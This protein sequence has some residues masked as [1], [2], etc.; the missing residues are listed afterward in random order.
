[1]PNIAK[2]YDEDVLT[3]S[4]VSIEVLSPQKILEYS[5]CE[6]DKPFD[7]KTFIGTLSDPK[8]GPINSDTLCKTCGYGFKDCPGHFGHIKLAKPMF[9]IVYFKA[10]IKILGLV[11]PN[12]DCASVL[13]NTSN[14]GSNKTRFNTAVK[15]A[16]NVNE[17]PKCSTPTCKYKKTINNTYLCIKKEIKKK[18]DKNDTSD[19]SDVLLYASNVIKL[20]SRISDKDC[21]SIGL[22]PVTSRPEWMLF[23]YLPVAPPTVRP[24]VKTDSGKSSDDDLTL[25]YNDIIKCNKELLQ[26]MMN[27]EGSDDDTQPSSSEKL[28]QYNIITLIDNNT[29]GL[30]K[31]VHKNGGRPLKSF[32]ERAGGKEGRFRSHLMGK[33]VDGSARSVISCNQS[34]SIDEVGVP[35]EIIRNLTYP[36]R[37]TPYNINFLNNLM[38][39]NK[40]KSVQKTLRKPVDQLKEFK[41]AG[42]VQLRKF[43]EDINAVDTKMNGRI[44]AEIMLLK[45]A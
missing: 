37:V 7:Q 41:A 43:L 45:V 3:V 8:M 11:C 17:C 24:T 15:I 32:R 5:C 1:M 6:I 33:R 35:E 19:K 4:K 34:L 38:E 18:Q 20:F 12:Y 31:A 14:K 39:K 42:K 13:F 44:N 23:T 2:P 25:K 9:N 26:A 40:V 29:S 21:E 16:K 28:L 27:I 10:V 22:N 30:P 36:E